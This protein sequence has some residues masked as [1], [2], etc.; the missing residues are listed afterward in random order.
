MAAR[1]RG[2][3]IRSHG[4][5]LKRR[6]TP[7]KRKKKSRPAVLSINEEKYKKRWDVQIEP[8]LDVMRTRQ[9]KGLAPYDQ[10]TNYLKRE[11]YRVIC[12]LWDASG[13]LNVIEAA[14]AGCCSSLPISPALEDNPFFWG[15]KAIAARTELK[16][17]QVTRLSQEM[18][19]AKRHRIS[20][21]LLV[22][23]IMQTGAARIYKKD[24]NEWE[25]WYDENEPVMQI[26]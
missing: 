2:A 16:P 14:V 23:F 15:L 24:S 4:K 26:N 18:M 17:Y 11:V 7:T 6:P 22:G 12:K 25:S 10:R 20:P 9:S 13:G 19:Y 3:S 8:I 5:K 21:D 1:K